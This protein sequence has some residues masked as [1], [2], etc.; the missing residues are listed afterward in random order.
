VQPQTFQVRLGAEGHRHRLHAVLQRDR[1]RRQGPADLP[2]F[3]QGLELEFRAPAGKAV[4]AQED[5]YFHLGLLPHLGGGD[6]GDDGSIA[7]L[8]RP[9]QRGN[10][11]RDA[12]PAPEACH[13]VHLFRVAHSAVGNH[14]HRRWSLAAEAARQ[15]PECRGELAIGIVRAREFAACEELLQVH[16]NEP[17]AETVDMYVRMLLLALDGGAEQRDALL[18]AG[19]GTAQE[20]ALRGVE[21]DVDLGPADGAGRH[22]Y[23]HRVQADHYEGGQH[24]APEEP[25]KPIA[26]AVH[27]R[28]APPLHPP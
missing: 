2:G 23:A 9:A 4:G 8:G 14:D 27:R 28:P 21:Q 15:L 18:P 7:P 25:Q 11:H 20:H 12:Q 6:G 19:L 17:L 1:K 24:A 16:A 13:L 22:G 5:V 10:M 26:G 3:I